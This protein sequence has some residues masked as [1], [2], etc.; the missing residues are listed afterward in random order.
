MHEDANF[1]KDDDGL[2][3]YRIVDL[4]LVSV[5]LASESVDLKE[6]NKEITKT[7]SYVEKEEKFWKDCFGSGAVFGLTLLK[8]RLLE[9]A[10]KEA[11]KNS[12]TKK[13]D[14]NITIK[15]QVSKK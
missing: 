11:K 1:Y 3:K 10:E 7:I 2:W 4:K 14:K 8:K 9:K 6:L 15:N 13:N 5:R 12:N